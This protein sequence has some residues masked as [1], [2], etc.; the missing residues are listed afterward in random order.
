MPSKQYFNLLLTR[1]EVY[2]D[3]LQLQ[4][5]LGNASK[6]SLAYVFLLLCVIQ[7]IFYN[8]WNHSHWQKLHVK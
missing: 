4:M 5:T 6:R 2:F 3:L 7:C 1:Q 8:A